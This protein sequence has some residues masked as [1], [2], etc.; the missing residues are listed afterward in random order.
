MRRQRLLL[1]ERQIG[2]LHRAELDRVKKRAR[3]FG[4]AQQNTY[5]RYTCRGGEHRHALDKLRAQI[6]RLARHECTDHLRGELRRRSRRDQ[7]EHLG[8]GVARLRLEADQLLDGGDAIGIAACG[9][10]GRG[11]KRRYDLVGVLVERL[12]APGPG[13]PDKLPFAAGRRFCEHRQQLRF[14]GGRQVDGVIS[15]PAAR[16]PREEAF[17][18]RRRG[19]I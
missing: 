9:V 10:R 7:V 17:D 19:P 6:G 13:K 15:R 3:G 2:Q 11:Q 4:T 8:D 5:R 18:H 12:A 16:E 14:R 1:I